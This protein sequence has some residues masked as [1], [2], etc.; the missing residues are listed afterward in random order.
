MP[1]LII[2]GITLLVI[3]GISFY[4]KKKDH[5]GLGVFFSLYCVISI[6]IYV[7]TLPEGKPFMLVDILGQI[8]VLTTAVGVIIPH[9]KGAKKAFYILPGLLILAISLSIH[10]SRVDQQSQNGTAI[11]QTLTMQSNQTEQEEKS[12]QL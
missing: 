7:A 3:I 11:N 10:I 2:A 12:P 5:S 1:A 6:I 4:A 9:A 8:G